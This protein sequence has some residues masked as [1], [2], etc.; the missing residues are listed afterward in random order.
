MLSELL[1]MKKNPV[2]NPI[3]VLLIDDKSDKS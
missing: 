1:Y 2:I 3:Q